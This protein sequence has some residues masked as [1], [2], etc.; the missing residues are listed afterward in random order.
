MIFSNFSQQDLP[1]LVA[2]ILIL[3]FMISRLAGGGMTFSKIAKYTVIW[4]LFG[5]LIII[6]YSYRFDFIDLK[7]RIF[8]ELNPSKPSIDKENKIIINISQDQHF[9]IQAKINQKDILFLV[10]TGASDITLAKE[11]AKKVGI[12]LN[13]LT[14]NRLYQTA[15][16]KSWGASTIIEELNIANS[17]FKNVNISINQNQMGTSL[18][19]MSGLRKFK[20][21]EFYNDKLILT[22]N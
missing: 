6:I 17:S 13:K 18:F 10:D 4:G 14:F 5:L 12:N 3:V 7:Q 9:Y 21:Y 22:P 2:S 11:D 1:S 15:N 20:K 19:G 8:S 16:G